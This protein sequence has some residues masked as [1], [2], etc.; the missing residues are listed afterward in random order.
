[1]TELDINVATAARVAAAAAADLETFR[2]F[3]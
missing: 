2:S 1:L 3:I